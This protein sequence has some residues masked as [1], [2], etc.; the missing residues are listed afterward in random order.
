MIHLIFLVTSKSF[1]LETIM[2]SLPIFNRK[3][4]QVFVSSRLLSVLPFGVVWGLDGGL[5][6]CYSNISTPIYS[7]PIYLT[8]TIYQ[9]SSHNARYL[10]TSDG[11]TGM[12]AVEDND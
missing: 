10:R 7:L 1:C 11:T 12:R 2:D 8:L 4:K 9:E 5:V 6:G 3:H